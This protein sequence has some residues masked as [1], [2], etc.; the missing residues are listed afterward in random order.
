ML[1]EDF[2]IE[3][4]EVNG[5]PVRTFK[6]RYRNLR[7]MF[8][9]SVTAYGKDTYLI[10]GDHRLT[11]GDTADLAAGMAEMLRKE[12][13]VSKGDHVGLLMENTVRF[14]IAFWAIQELGAAAVVF[15]TR[16]AP[17]E[18]KRQL[19]FSDLTALLSTPAQSGKTQD[20][21]SGGWPFKHIVLGDDWKSGLPR[22]PSPASA[23][24]I[25]ED[26]TALILFTSGTVGVPKGVMIT[27]RNLITSAFKVGYISSQIKDLEEVG[28]MT[29]LIAAP[30]FH[31]MAIQ[32]QMI[33]AVFL[34]QACILMPAFEPKAFLELF[35]RNRVTNLVGTPTMYWLLLNK[36]PL[37]GT[38]P[39]SV[40][41]IGY[42]GAPMPPDLLKDIRRTFPGVLCMNGYGLTE[43]SVISLLD[44]RYCESH[45]TSVG[46]PHLCSEVKIEDP[47][48]GKELGPNGVGELAV[49]GALVS[50]GYYK[51]SEETTSFYR[52]GWFYT[53]DMAY[54][55]ADGFIYVVGRTREMIN[56]GGENVYPVEVEN[57]LHL[58]PKILDVAVFGLPDPVMG[59][60]VACA[61]VSRPDMEQITAEEL[62]AI[63]RDQLASYKIPQRI[64]FLPDL[65]K[66]SGGKVIKG[67]LIEQFQKT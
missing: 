28:Q 60:V 52:K 6:K 25:D 35:T 22:T 42:G 11:Y 63:C 23:G 50:R 58:H 1:I 37:R 9:Q 14:V 53:G 20:A 21:P 17:S 64:F 49:R 27:H 7:Q 32:E 48:S 56:R 30:L 46:R 33:P 47:L 10:E 67:K 34:G 54:Q 40:R 39:D 57:V 18:L 55:D 15:N 16:L 36:T 3:T 12:A 8:S 19:Q 41:I 31:V 59:S 51:S 44:D 2:S 4:V 65:P 62:Q 45:P 38:R 66:N 5:N 29:G 61:I 43:A 24:D 13:G 26:E